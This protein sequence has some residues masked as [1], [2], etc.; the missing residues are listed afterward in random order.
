MP[1]FIIVGYVWQILGK[2]G[3]F[4]PPIRKQPRKC[5]SW[6]GSSRVNL[7]KRVNL[8]RESNTIKLPW[9]YNTN[10]I[11]SYYSAMVIHMAEILSSF[12]SLKIRRFLHCWNAVSVLPKFVHWVYQ[13]QECQNFSCANWRFL[14]EKVFWASNNYFNYFFIVFAEMSLRILIPT[15]PNEAYAAILG[16]SS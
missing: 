15:K 4:A 13:Q 5:P 3:F 6:I 9:N 16:Y 7:N 11:R 10:V 2:G 8:A 12:G 14:S 1:S